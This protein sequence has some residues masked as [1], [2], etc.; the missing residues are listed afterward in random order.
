MKQKPLRARLAHALLTTSVAAAGAWTSATS[1]A[2]EL[3]YFPL[4]PSFGGS[5]LNGPVLLNAA[6]A[7]NKYTDPAADEAAAARLAVTAKTPLQQFNEMLERSIL[8]RLASNA[9]AGLMGEGGNLQ[10]GTVETGNFI[11]NIVDLGG[12]MLRITTTD[13]ANGTS[14]SFEVAS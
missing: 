6:Q 4:N 13:K 7:Q 8:N 9:S 10:P 3:V 12:G 11:I 2:S 14:S 1:T 5:P